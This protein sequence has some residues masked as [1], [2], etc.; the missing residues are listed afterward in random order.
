MRKAKL[1]TALAV[2]AL[3]LSNLCACGNTGSSD[4]GKE[5]TIFTT[6]A[7]PERKKPSAEFTKLDDYQNWAK[8]EGYP[9]NILVAEG[10]EGVNMDYFHTPEDSKGYT[11]GK[12]VVGDSRCCQMGI[13]EVRSEG[14]DAAVFAVWGGH[15]LSSAEPPILSDELF[16]DLTKCFE[17][18]IKTAGECR[19]YF[20]RHGE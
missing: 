18:Q 20:F 15:Y 3:M 1:L 12:I 7:A 5:E 4:K 8:E 10:V 17:E 6:A 9:K 19:V 16:A 13:Y 14:A 2:S 11:S